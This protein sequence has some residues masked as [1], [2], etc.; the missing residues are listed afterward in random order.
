M[1]WLNAVLIVY[2]LL[3]IG[4]GVYG[5]V[6]KGSVMSLL[7]GGIGGLLILGSVAIY[8]LKPRLS[9]IG[10]AVVALIMAGS[11]A[12]KTFTANPP[13]H[14]ITIFA[15][16]ILIV[17]LLLGAHFAARSAKKETTA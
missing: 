15:T 17:I 10:A 7:G 9:R 3:M 1:K 4:L 13:W 6:E 16:S 12:K 5:F 2:G 11:M 14:A 8:P